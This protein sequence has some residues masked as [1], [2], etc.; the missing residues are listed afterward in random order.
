ML[1]QASPYV[2]SKLTAIC[3]GVASI[4]PC[5][6]PFTYN[7]FIFNYRILFYILLVLLGS[8]TGAWIAATPSLIIKLLERRDCPLPLVVLH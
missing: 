6:L 4:C 7:I 1:P 2:S 8:T 5:L 3:L